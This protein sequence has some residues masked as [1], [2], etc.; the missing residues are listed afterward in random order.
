MPTVSFHLGPELCTIDLN[1]PSLTRGQAQDAM[2]LTNQVIFENRPIGVSYGTAE[3]FAARGVRKQVMREG[4]L[5]AIEIAD[6]DLQPCGGTHVMHTGQVGLVLVRKIEKQKQ[7]WRVEF[8]CGLRAL[9]SA[10]RDFD[11]LAEA[12][13]LLS[14]GP[15][16]IPAVLQKALQE[17]QHLMR[18]RRRLQEELAHFDARELLES[19]SGETPDAV[20]RRR[21][22]RIFD[23]AE[24][25]YLRLLATKVT[26]VSGV[27]VCLASRSAGHV[28]AAQSPGGP[29]DMAALLRAALSRAGGKGGGT[30]VF[31]QGSVP[32]TTRLDE[33]VASLFPQS[34]DI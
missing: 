28:V 11:L 2:E 12:A 13:Q 16:D 31:A 34:I 3:D 19:L 17:R 10:Q 25:E 7:N 22:A 1:A 9:R 18:A 24:P 5:R 15:G 30:R 20:G 14:C 29:D 33:V 23:E 6:F 27:Q 4:T 8:V 32:D 21:L 26:E